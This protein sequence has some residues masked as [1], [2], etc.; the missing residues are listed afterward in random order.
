MAGLGITSSPVQSSLGLPP[1]HATSPQ[2]ASVGPPIFGFF[3][4]CGAD[5]VGKRVRAGPLLLLMM[6]T[7]ALA[8]SFVS[9]MMLSLRKTDVVSAFRFFLSAAGSS[10]DDA[11]SALSG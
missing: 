7:V 10:F 3:G 5:N 2:F 9:P 11:F 6:S 8:A 1:H 4:A